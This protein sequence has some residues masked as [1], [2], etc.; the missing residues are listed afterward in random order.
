MEKR[1]RAMNNA[2]G[3]HQLKPNCVNRLRRPKTLV[4]DMIEVREPDPNRL[5]RDEKGEAYFQRLHYSIRCWQ[6]ALTSLFGPCRL[7]YR[8]Q[9]AF[10]LAS[11]PSLRLLGYPYLI[12][13]T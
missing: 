5:S 12:P 6:A 3:L 1:E 7:V 9:F 4:L 11:V 8:A 10:A 13:P 2:A